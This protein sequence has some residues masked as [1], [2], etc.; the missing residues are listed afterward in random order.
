MKTAAI[1]PYALVAAA[2]LFAPQSASTQDAPAENSVTAELK[3]LVDKVYPAYVLIGGGSGVC[4]SSDGYM[5]TNHHVADSAVAKYD[6]D[7][8][9]IELLVR[10][11]GKGKPLTARPVGGDPRGDIVLLKIESEEP[12]PFTPL[13]DSD[14]VRCGDIAVAIGNPFMLSGSGSEPSVSAGVVSAVGRYQGGYSDCFQVDAPVNPGNSGGPSFNIKGEIIGINGRI[15]TRHGQRYN[16]GAG[17]VISANQIKRFMESFKAQ[18]G[19]AILVRHALISGLAICHDKRLEGVEVHAVRPG[20]TA[21]HAG[22]EKGDIVTHVAQYAIKG[23]RG[24]YGK[25]CTWPLGAEVDFTVKRGAE[26]IQLKARLDVPVKHNQS[27]LLPHVDDEEEESW[28]F[29]DGNVREADQPNMFAIPAPRVA[30]GIRMRPTGNW[31]GGFEVVG[32]PKAGSSYVT[33]ANESLKEGDVVTHLNGRPMK[34]TAEFADCMLG[35]K[36]GDKV[37]IT[38]TRDGATAEAEV[39]LSKA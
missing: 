37:K 12:L 21:S 15:L 31:Q 19:G 25:V 3:A 9:P 32:F 29:Q 36:P 14:E 8:K 23:W 2:A 6:A 20:S 24:F 35:F 30:L 1:I 27:P 4:I 13:A 18:P 16:T 38:Y 34:Y 5:L 22:F 33:N 10:M 11:A 17:Y 7:G 28:I 26:E 39:T